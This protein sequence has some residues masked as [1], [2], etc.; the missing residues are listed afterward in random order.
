MSAGMS[1][2]LIVICHQW[3]LLVV[4]KSNRT[5]ESSLDRCSFGCWLSW[6]VTVIRG[7]IVQ[8]ACALPLCLPKIVTHPSDRLVLLDDENS[9]S[10]ADCHGEL[11]GVLE[12][13]QIC[14][15]RTLRGH[16]LEHRSACSSPGASL[17]RA[18]CC[19]TIRS[20]ICN[21][22]NMDHGSARL[23]QISNMVCQIFDSFNANLSRWLWLG[24]ASRYQIPSCNVSVTDN[25]CT[26]SFEWN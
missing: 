15:H 14:P 7:W 24:S 3:I 18:T 5:L 20:H 22:F 25:V 17:S 23:T 26:W 19:W 12:P 4:A 16:L 21:S 10:K 13:N 1:A 11:L 8:N 9:T 6:W 2:L